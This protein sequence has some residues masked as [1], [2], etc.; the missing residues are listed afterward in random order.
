MREL[1]KILCSAFYVLLITASTASAIQDP[2]IVYG[3][4][5]YDD[6]SAVTGASVSISV[7]EQVLTETTNSEGKY[8]G[9]L[10]NYTDGDRIT[11]TASRETY[12]GS[13]EESLDKASGG[14][15]IKVILQDGAAPGSITS[16]E[17]TT[18][19]FWINWTWTNPDDSGFGYVV[20]YIDDVRTSNVS[21]SYYQDSY[22]PHSIK[23][24]SIQ[25]VDIHG[26]V[27][28]TRVSQTTEIPNNPVSLTNIPSSVVIAEGQTLY[29]DADAVDADS[30][31]PEF[32]CSRTDLFPDFNPS[33]GQGSFT[34]TYGQSGTYH[35]DFR[36][37]DGYGSI[38]N[39]T[40]VLTVS[41]VPLSIVSFW[42]NVT[43]DAAAFTE[44]SNGNSVEFGTGM[45]RIPTTVNWYINNVLI[46]SSTSLNMSHQWDTV[47]T[48][49]VNVSASDSYDTTPIATW[50]V[51]VVTPPNGPGNTF[52][53]DMESG[54][55]G[56]VASGLWH[57]TTKRSDSPTNSWWYGQESTG[58]YDTGAA[59]SG[60]LTSPSISLAGSSNTN[61]S[62]KSWYKT[63]AG[64][65]WDKK[66]VQISTDNGASW[67]DIKQISDTPSTWNLETI[68][69]SGYAGQTI[70]IRFY[71][72]TIDNLYNNY[73][74]WF[75]DDVKIEYDTIPDPTPTPEPGIIFSD[76]IESG[77]NS[78]E[79]SGLWHI[80]T[81][82]SVSP[83]HSWW[84]GQELTG[85]YDTGLANSGSLTSS[86]ISLIGSSNPELS[87][88]SWYKTESG[89]SYDKKI[90]Q[91][92]IDSGITWTDLKQISDTP[93]TWNLETIDLS[94]YADQ[95]IYIRF[96]FNT[97]DKL[98]NDYEGWY[99]DDVNIVG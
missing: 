77:T 74:G 44:V 7:P 40:M 62:F 80:A 83:S 38:S 87:F 69:L 98:Y 6:G 61:L 90:V 16:L 37:S 9:V 30:D 84:Y 2:F 78:W 14:S 21:A 20:V 35:I 54:P 86:S 42:N 60:Y 96:Y 95:T 63:E 15:L 72:N 46:Q 1:L 34:P 39:K 47:G 51:D 3:Y 33:T 27:N 97:I 45:N 17:S 91:I 58:N 10:D 85:N 65:S 36:A 5:R 28:N 89:T 25:T 67:I 52:I 93:S 50:I 66:I 4:V 79:S 13:A 76:D 18:G 23:T 81:E 75:I 53:D 92:S 94:G 68:D 29:V 57:M 82:R 49:Y 24:I 22:A 48:Y 88:K 41:D 8:I 19:N 43:K 73:E 31:I 70:Y 56:W 59:N 12:T 64:T 32:H 55:N 71:F 11:V 26:N 99:I